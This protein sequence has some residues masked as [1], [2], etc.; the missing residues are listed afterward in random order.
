MKLFA[1]LCVA[2]L[3][4]ASVLT[5]TEK[6]PAKLFSDMPENVK[7]VVDKSCFG[8]HNTESMNDKAK[9]KLDFKLLDELS[10]V[11]KLA[12][13]NHIG[14]TVE[15][16]EMPPQKFLERFPDK[17]LTEDEVKVL[18]EWVKSSTA[19]LMQE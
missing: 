7:A 19:S 5:A 17:A 11:K 18:T 14:E 6:T 12:A 13:L 8:C 4:S 16:K 9:E 2:F 15:K 10:T 1:L 3:F